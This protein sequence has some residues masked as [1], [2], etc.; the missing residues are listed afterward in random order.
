MEFQLTP[1]A[2]RLFA[3][4]TAALI[5]RRADIAQSEA[6]RERWHILYAAF[7]DADTASVT[8][9][10][11]AANYMLYVW[12]TPDVWRDEQTR[13]MVKA[14]L[15]PQWKAQFPYCVHP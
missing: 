8:V 13:Q 9:P 12:G 14:Q 7:R 6:E 5:R 2:A 11:D 3:D 4:A 1:D 15:R 10:R